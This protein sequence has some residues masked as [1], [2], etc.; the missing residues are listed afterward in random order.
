[1]HSWN[2]IIILGLKEVASNRLAKVILVRKRIDG[3]FG[4]RVGRSKRHKGSKSLLIT[5]TDGTVFAERLI[6]TQPLEKFQAFYG[7]QMLITMFITAHI[8]TPSFL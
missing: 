5:A 6:T 8:L 2:V 3:E 1:M 7:I 4:A